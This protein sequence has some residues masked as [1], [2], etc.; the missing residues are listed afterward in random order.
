MKLRFIAGGEKII[1]SRTLAAKGEK[2]ISVQMPEDNLVHFVFLK[3][4]GKERAL[5]FDVEGR[6]MYERNEDIPF[7]AHFGDL[8]EGE[9][10]T[11]CLAKV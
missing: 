11:L 7:L 5:F 9:A 2:G 3:Q 10:E 6:K 8:S 4:I 1:N